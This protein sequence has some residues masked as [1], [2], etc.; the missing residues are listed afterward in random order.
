VLTTVCAAAAAIARSMR[1]PIVFQVVVFFWLMLIAFFTVLRL[2]YICRRI[3]QVQNRLRQQR[4]DLE[5]MVSEKRRE[6]QQAKSAADRQP[7]SGS[8]T[9]D[10]P[11]AR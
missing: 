6:I 4:A 8:M 2:P 1:V 10:D 3:F 9:P 7:L 11:P 5:A